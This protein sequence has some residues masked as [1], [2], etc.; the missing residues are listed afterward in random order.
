MT[1]LLILLLLCLH[2]KYCC[3]ITGGRGW[4][5]RL[6][7]C[8]KKQ[9][10]WWAACVVFEV[11]DLWQNQRYSLCIR[12]TSAW[13]FLFAFPFMCGLLRPLLYIHCWGEW[14]SLYTHCWGEWLSLY[15]HCWGEWLSTTLDYTSP[16][17]W[18]GY[19]RSMHTIPEIGL[20]TSSISLST[21]VVLI[22]HWIPTT[23]STVNNYAD[24]DL[25]RIIGER[26][27]KRLLIQ[28]VT[29][30]NWFS[31][32]TDACNSGA[33]SDHREPISLHQA[34]FM[35]AINQYKA[36]M[37]T[38]KLTVCKV[39]LVWQCSVCFLPA[40]SLMVACYEGHIKVIQ[41]LRDAGAHWTT[42]DRAGRHG[43]N[44]H[45]SV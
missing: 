39:D 13:Y 2:S 21:Y 31:D 16:D 40:N 11:I 37:L 29:Q 20:S 38:S 43:N 32:V 28:P 7:C 15:T 14:L 4:Y 30:W 27:A 18:N 36:L 41:Q 8:W 19:K 6:Q 10:L 23:S 42:A 34:V 26:H 17:N 9:G 1:S 5:W 22:F 25:V 33:S 45:I 12:S 44:W 3:C 35:W 24:Y